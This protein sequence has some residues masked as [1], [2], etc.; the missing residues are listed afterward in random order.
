MRPN[1]H[2]A[3]TLAAPRRAR[4]ALLGLCLAALALAGCGGSAA[5]GSS[6]F[7]SGAAAPARSGGAA[8]FARPGDEALAY[9]SADVFPSLL[10]E[11]DFVQ[12][13]APD[14]DAL[15]RLRDGLA[16]RL[17]K[18]AGVH[19]VIDSEIPRSYARGR[20]QAGDL[21]A[22]ESQFRRNSTADRANP[23]QAV[24]WIVYVPGRSEAD[25]EGDSALGVAYGAS[26]IAVFPESIERT[27]AAEARDV[28][29][30]L[31]LVHECGHLAGLV[32]NGIPMVRG[33]EDGASARHDAR[34][35]CVMAHCV[36]GGPV[37]R[38]LERPPLDFCYAC[39][40]DLYAA[41]GPL[42]GFDE[43]TLEPIQFSDALDAAG[44][45]APQ[46]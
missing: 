20:W 32:N 18:P 11:V 17:G 15:A 8:S 36:Q 29:E 2:P 26:A 33:H 4:S 12:G 31:T 21:L 6:A 38:L 28:V 40:L 5:G 30:T 19:V 44:K 34:A 22:L 1:P 45:R 25:E 16:R 7:P 14:P 42:P 27:T 39:R 24:I 23:Y 9:I 35:S 41:G 3:W 10:V 37:A 43:T 13:V 46:Q